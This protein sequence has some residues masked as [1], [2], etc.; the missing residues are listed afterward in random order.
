MVLGSVSGT[1]SESCL[2][3]KNKRTKMS[4]VPRVVFVYGRLKVPGLVRVRKEVVLKYFYFGRDDV[5]NM[6]R[7][8]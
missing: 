8:T 6:R 2:F 7:V 3:L 1:S 4:L 5:I